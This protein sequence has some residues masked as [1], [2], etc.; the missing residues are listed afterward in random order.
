MLQF[1]G[2]MVVGSIFG[3]CLMCIMQ[4]NRLY[5]TDGEVRE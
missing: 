2:G 1:I 4:I 5:K 3:V